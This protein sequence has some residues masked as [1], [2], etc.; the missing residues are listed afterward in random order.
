[1]RDV[2]AAV[3]SSSKRGTGSCEGCPEAGTDYNHPGLFNPDADVLVVE[4]APSRSHFG[5]PDYDR[6][7]D[8][9]RYEQFFEEE[10]RA[11]IAGWP[12]VELF[13]APV[14]EGL[15]YDREDVFDL[16]YTTSAV[17]CA[18]R[19]LE[20]PYRHCE[21]HLA[22]SIEAM[23]PAVV[24]TTRSRPTKWTAR[25]PG[26]SPSETLRFKIS[27]PEWWDRTDVDTEPPMVH[28]PHWEYSPSALRRVAGRGDP[29]GP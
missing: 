8:V 22:R 23:D 12:P 4:E 28:V 1:M 6:S 13:L 24:V 2:R 26:V 16:V 20:E 14:F 9:V 7:N 15:G 17:T 25:L 29:G 19:D 18:T 3:W 10:N 5:S 21:S 11:V 27:S